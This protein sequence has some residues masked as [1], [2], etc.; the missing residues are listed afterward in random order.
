MINLTNQSKFIIHRDEVKQE[1]YYKNLYT[2][3]ILLA[4]ANVKGYEDLTDSV[5]QYLTSAYPGLS[6]YKTVFTNFMKNS[7]RVRNVKESR[8]RWR[9]RGNGKIQTL[10]KGNL[11]EGNP[12]PGLNFSTI[13]L[14]LDTEGFRD[15]DTLS[16]EIE[17]RVQV[18]IQGEGVADGDGYRY[19]ADL[20]TTE[21]NDFLDPAFLEDD[22]RWRKSGSSKYSEGSSGYGSFM[23]GG[24][25]WIEFEVDLSKTGKAV[26][27][28]DEAHTTNLRLSFADDVTHKLQGYPDQ[29]LSMIEAEFLAQTEW[30]KEW[31]LLWGRTTKA[32]IDKTTG[33]H[34]RV[35][36]GLFQ[37]LEDGNVTYYST[38]GGSIEILEDAIE[39]IQFDRVDG[40]DGNVVVYTG[41]EG[42]KIAD[43]WIRA[44]YGDS[45]VVS[46]YEDYVDKVGER[47]LKFKS[48]LFNMYEIPTF[49]TIIFEHWPALDSVSQ[50]G[51]KHPISGKPLTSY[52]M[53][54]LDYGLNAGGPG[55]IELLNREGHKFYT[56]Y[57]GTWSPAGPNNSGEK[58]PHTVGHRG[59]SYELLHGDEY[60]LRV[61]DITAVVHLKPN[62]V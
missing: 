28:T 50:G 7:G 10:S 58:M 23:H 2:E 1:D 27:V 9:L 4:N 59:R 46:K 36:A 14:W 22:V 40:M 3:N 55:N 54:I 49:G 34:R 31:D 15:G 51:P 35:G 37:Y 44:K 20:A 53:I 29:V 62:I 52:E 60:G 24:V 12:N 11:Q 16:P 39:T 18:I 8:V 38:E 30:E 33:L 43:R 48:K 26:E 17:P 56:Y 21:A 61:K 5:V 41:R 13:Y 57:C 25:S 32:S 6:Q 42:L 45:A 47:N 19:E